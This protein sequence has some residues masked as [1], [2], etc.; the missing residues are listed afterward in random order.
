MKELHPIQMDI[1]RKLLFSASAKYSELKQEDMENAQFV[2][3]LDKLIKEQLV[4]KLERGYKLTDL[5]K[6]FANRMDSTDV[7]LKPQPK[8]TTILCA[9]KKENGEYFYLIWTKHKNPFY[10]AQGFPTHKVWFGEG[11]TDAAKSGLKDETGLEAEPQLVAIRQYRV[12]LKETTELVEDKI[13]YLH[14]FE[15]PVNE[16]QSCEQGIYEWV[17]ESDIQLYVT[18]PLPEFYETLELV[19]NFNGTINFKEDTFI[20]DKF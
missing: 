5:G 20:T 15:N 10:G 11:I 13:M 14:L 19:K 6:E 8:T 17:K 12:Y 4:E 1:L 9:R 7:I 16:L 18:N 2:F 3:H